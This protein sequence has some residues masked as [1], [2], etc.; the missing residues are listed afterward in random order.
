MQLSSAVFY[1]TYQ[2]IFAKYQ[3]KFFFLHSLRC[4]FFSLFIFGLWNQFIET[5]WSENLILF[6]SSFFILL[7]CFWEP[8]EREKTLRDIRTSLEIRYPDTQYSIWEL[9]EQD[10]PEA[11]KEWSGVLIKFSQDVE[12]V[13]KY[14]LSVF[15]STLVIPFFLALIVTSPVVT[16]ANH[17]LKMAG[18]FLKFINNQPVLHILQGQTQLTDLEIDD[19]PLSTSEVHELELASQNLIQISYQ[20]ENPKEHAIVYLHPLNKIEEVYQSF[21]MNVQK[22]QDKDD[23][24][25]YKITFSV[26]QDLSLSIP[27]SFGEHLVAHFKL[28]QLPYPKV[29]LTPMME[30]TDPWH[31]EKP[32]ELNIEASSQAPMKIVNLIIK[33][34]SR[35]SEELVNN[36]TSNDIYTYNTNY[37]LVLENYLSEDVADVE[38]LAQVI[39]AASPTPLI[40]YSNPIFVRTESAYGR[41]RHSLQVLRQLKTNV[42]QSIEGNNYHLTLKEKDLIDDAFQRSLHTPYF[43]QI[44]RLNL[45][46]IQSSIQEDV[47]NKTMK[48]TVLVKNFLDEFLLEHEILDDRERDRDFFVASRA[49]SRLIEEDKDERPIPVELAIKNLQHFLKTR[50]ARW[51]LRVEKLQLA[52]KLPQWKKIEQNKPFIQ[53]LD[54]ILQNV[55]QESDENAKPLLTLSNLSSDYRVWIESLEKAED[56]LRQQ[57]DQKRQEGLASARKK[58]R[59]LQKRQ[60]KISTDLDNAYAQKKEDLEDKWPLI[61][62]KQNTNSKETRKLTAQLKALSPSAGMR[63][64]AAYKSMLGVLENGENSNYIK[65]ES[66]SDL[67]GR[68]LRKAEKESQ[69]S[70][71]NKQRRVRK[72]VTGDQYYGQ[73]VHGGDLEIS[74]EY[75]VDKKY[76]EEILGEFQGQEKNEDNQRIIDKYLRSII[77]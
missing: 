9:D 64:E 7:Y 43:D 48:H 40:G 75:Q 4:L 19:Y 70:I 60:G 73:S 26:D 55:D 2:S 57:K 45:Q 71:G 15:L 49:L 62:L 20:S 36:I 65:A 25:E 54:E 6:F 59:E 27:A 10:K 41:Y 39:D 42:D 18:K 66:Y 16:S 51:K 46:N 76:R 68:L 37:S 22:L 3:K 33:V 1:Q 14:R 44:D 77:R 13:L 61:R 53:K 28:Q 69:K 72:R 34:G 58:L 11:Q 47:T 50:R 67:A 23:V 30:I 52:P 8:I 17:T 32:L 31:D 12:K 63:I 21:K 74:R 56:Q 35:K 38:I 29:S 24:F 5:S